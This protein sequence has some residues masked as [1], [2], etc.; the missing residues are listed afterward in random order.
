MSWIQ[1]QEERDYD[2]QSEY[3]AVLRAEAFDPYEF[4]VECEEH[5]EAFDLRFDACPKCPVV[6]PE[7]FVSLFEGEEPPF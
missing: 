1:A 3:L 6:E 4:I 7:P 2:T 5:R